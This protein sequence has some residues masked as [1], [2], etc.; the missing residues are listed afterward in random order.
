MAILRKFGNNLIFFGGMG[1][2]GGEIQ[3][4]CLLIGLV[5]IKFQEKTS[6][7]VDFQHLSHSSDHSC[8][9]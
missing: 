3:E 9:R 4:L 7:R 5:F 6:S 1:F 2:S 8:I